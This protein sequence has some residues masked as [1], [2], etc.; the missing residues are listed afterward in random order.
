MNLIPAL[1]LLLKTEQNHNNYIIVQVHVCCCTKFIL[2]SYFHKKFCIIYKEKK[3]PEYLA[4]IYNP[5]FI[6]S[7]DPFPWVNFKN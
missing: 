5:Q 7:H 3:K 1:S 4:S 6:L 2:P